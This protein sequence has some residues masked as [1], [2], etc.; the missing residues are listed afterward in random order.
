M[1]SPNCLTKFSF[2][3]QNPIKNKTYIYKYEEEEEKNFIDPTAGKHNC[4]IF[5]LDLTELSICHMCF[6][7]YY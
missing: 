6:Q 7:K 4:S 5:A 3:T 1:A 2:K